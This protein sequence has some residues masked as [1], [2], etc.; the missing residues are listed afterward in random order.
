[1]EYAGCIK[2]ITKFGLD[3]QKRYLRSEGRK[4]ALAKKADIL[5]NKRNEG[6]PPASQYEPSYYLTNCCIHTNV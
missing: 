5:D 3:K 4:S 1:M 2:V 6:N